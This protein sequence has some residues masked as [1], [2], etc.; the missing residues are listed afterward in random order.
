VSRGVRTAETRSGA[1][2]VDIDVSSLIGGSRKSLAASSPAV[3]WS[4]TRAGREVARVF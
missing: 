3:R 4:R 1:S 2:V